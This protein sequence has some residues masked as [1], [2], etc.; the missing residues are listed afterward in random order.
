MEVSADVDGPSS[1]T[2]D[3]ETATRIATW[4]VSSVGVGSHV[5]AR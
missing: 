1:P 4:S 3:G 2:G 5:P